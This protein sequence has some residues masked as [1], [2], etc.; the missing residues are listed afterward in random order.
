[1]ELF[2]GRLFYNN[3]TCDEFL[4]FKQGSYYI[5]N[6]NIFIQGLYSQYNNDKIKLKLVIK[7]IA[8]KNIKKI[9]E[10]VK[11][12][13]DCYDS[14]S[15]KNDK[16]LKIVSNSM[17]GSTEQ[18]QITNLNKIISKVIKEVVIDNIYYKTT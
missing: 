5:G 3:N 8:N 9:P 16:Y 2:P 17:S 14:E 7:Q 4:I 12:N 11:E 18:E 10:W 6:G 1:M 15:K 13:P